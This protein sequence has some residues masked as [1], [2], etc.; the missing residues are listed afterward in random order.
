MEKQKKAQN[1]KKTS[2]ALNGKALAEHRRK[3]KLALK[4]LDA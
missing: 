2:E 3:Q 4:L 1:T